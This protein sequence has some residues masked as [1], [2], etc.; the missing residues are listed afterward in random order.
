MKKTKSLKVVKE[1]LGRGMPEFAMDA[2]ANSC[3]EQTMR[4]FIKYAQENTSDP[5]A[6]RKMLEKAKSVVKS[7]EEEIKEVIKR[8]AVEFIYNV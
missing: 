4:H 5:V 6:Q 3:S 2:I 1:E 8:K 7:L